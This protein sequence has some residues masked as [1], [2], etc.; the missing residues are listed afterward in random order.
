MVAPKRRPNRPFVWI[1]IYAVVIAT[2]FLIRGQLERP[3]TGL[4]FSTESDTVTTITLAGLELAPDLMPQLIKKY[5]DLYPKLHVIP[6]DGGTVRALEALAN[7][8]AQVG[9][10]YR[11]PTPEERALVRSAVD[12]TVL[13]FPIAL[14]GV[15]V[16]VNGLS[17]VES[18]S[19][20]DLRRLAR[21]EADPRFDRLYAPDPNQGLWDAFRIGLG[22]YDDSAPDNAYGRITFLKDEAAVI[23]AV[24][25]DPRG[26]GIASTLSLPDSLPEFAGGRSVRAVPVLPDTGLVP[27]EPGYEQIGYGEY[28]LYHYLYVACLANGS[29]RGSMF[30]THLTSDRGQRHVERAGYLPARQSIRQ[31]YLT[32]H[33]L[34]GKSN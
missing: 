14:G 7:R 28:P 22:V 12:D 18:F 8:R 32:R 34:G 29:I 5:H 3:G 16:L 15:A 13:C 19:M 33:P 24:L 1:A 10:L 17:G 25:A 20:D 27:V 9:L 30:V 4:R 6:E 31:I 21:D 26:L 23:E 2:V 11:L